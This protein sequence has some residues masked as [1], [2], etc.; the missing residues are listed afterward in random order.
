MEKTYNQNEIKTSR[1][2]GNHIERPYSEVVMELKA[3]G[4]QV[5]DDGLFAGYRNTEI[6]KDDIKIQL[7]CA[8]VDMDDFD[9]KA[10]SEEEFSLDAVEWY[11]E[12]VYENGEL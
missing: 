9:E 3:E 2:I 8:P 7:A 11:V 12:D 10:K 5:V 1:C 6:Q 4:Y